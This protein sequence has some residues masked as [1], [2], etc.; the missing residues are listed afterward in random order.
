METAVATPQAAIVAPEPKVVALAQRRVGLTA[1][2]LEQA[3]EDRRLVAEYVKG[4]MVKDVDFGTIPGTDKPTLLKPGAEKLVEL[5]HC[6]PEF[7]IV[8]AIKDFTDER[9]KGGFFYW[10]FRC[11]LFQR[12]AGA[13]IAEGY[14][15]CNSRE[16]RFRWRN[17]DRRCPAC[18][19][20]TIRRSRAEYGGGFYC[21]AKHGGCG[22]KFDADA[23]AILQQHVGRVEAED[24]ATHANNIEKIA[25]KRSLVDAAIAVARC[26][27]LFT[28][29]MEDDDEPGRT[30]SKPKPAPVDKAALEAKLKEVRALAEKLGFTER[31]VAKGISPLRTV[32]QAEAK[33]AELAKKMAAKEAAAKAATEPGAQG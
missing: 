24:A 33:R 27:D 22:S 12:D 20:P 9:F 26:S 16:T 2:I 1:D 30:P 7:E 15:S 17:E 19:Q 14:G 28:Q 10:E 32:E 13:V 23:P 18:H 8:E 6:T 5:Y 25:K 11:R 3:K 31:Q 21:A 4:Q 29:D